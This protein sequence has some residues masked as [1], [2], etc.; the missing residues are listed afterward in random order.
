[1]TKRT[2]KSIHYNDLYANQLRYA[3]QDSKKGLFESS[4]SFMERMKIKAK[5]RT[6]NLTLNYKV[7]KKR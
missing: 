5:R 1:M 7:Q 6:D 3:C 2:T 4:N